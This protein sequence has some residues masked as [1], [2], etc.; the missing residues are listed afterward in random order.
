MGRP[1]RLSEYVQYKKDI[2]RAISVAR[3]SLR[4]LDSHFIKDLPEV[5]EVT[6]SVNKFITK[7]SH[8][9]A[10]LSK[11]IDDKMKSNMASCNHLEVVRLVD[12]DRVLYE[13]VKCGH[14]SG[15]FSQDASIV[16]TIER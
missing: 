4:S 7:M 12:G 10:E 16:K 13:C 15:S 9:S 2:D 11:I 14:I 8:R 3:E 6:N 5:V 1:L